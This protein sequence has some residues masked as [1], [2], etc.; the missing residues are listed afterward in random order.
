MGFYGHWVMNGCSDLNV[1]AKTNQIVFDGVE[2]D[3]KVKM[4]VRGTAITRGTGAI[5]GSMETDLDF[6]QSSTDG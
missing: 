1:N 5:K 2:N 6:S 3:C 4:R